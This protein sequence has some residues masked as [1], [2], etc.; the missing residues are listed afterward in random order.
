M[1][2][3]KHRWELREARKNLEEVHTFLEEDLHNC[4]LQEDV[5]RLEVVVCREHTY[6]SR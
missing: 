4:V 3:C 2:A 5:A 6:I 1:I